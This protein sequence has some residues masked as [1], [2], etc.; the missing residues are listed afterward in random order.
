[1]IAREFPDFD[2]ATLPPIPEGWTD[3]S[4][5]NDACPSFT[6]GELQLFI[7]Y[8]DPA[9]RELGIEAPRFALMR[10]PDLT[11]CWSDEWADVLAAIARTGNG[12]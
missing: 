6:K 10:M 3:S 11:L 7:D 2:L 9:R 12:Q 4:W 8:A 1:M 5:H